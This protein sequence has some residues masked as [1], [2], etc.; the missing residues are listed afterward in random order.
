MKIEKT[1][2]D[3]TILS[4][5][6]ERVVRRRIALQLTQAELAE[7]SGVA[8]R[9][10]ERIEAGAS[11]QMLSL[12]RIFRVLD[13]LPNLDRMIP[14]AVPGPMELL[15]HKGKVRQRAAKSRNKQGSG[16]AWTWDDKT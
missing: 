4:E 16:K 13:L 11:A 10:L 8:K 5:L 12:I 3:L 15:K 14:E 9:T 6:G 7:R 2:A 1:L